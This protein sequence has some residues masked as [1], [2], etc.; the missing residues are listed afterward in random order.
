MRKTERANTRKRPNLLLLLADQL[1]LNA[2][3]AY[4]CPWVRTPNI[5]SLARFGV[6]FEHSVCTAPLCTP[7]RGSLLTGV[8]PHQHKAVYLNQVPDWK[9]VPQLGQALRNT[10]YRTV[11]GG[12]WHLPASYPL[13]GG[14]GISSEVPGF[15]LLP[16]FAVATGRDG[17]HWA[18]GEFTDEP[19]A[20]AAAQYI[21]TADT[22]PR[23]WML[24]LSFHQPHDICYF[25]AHPD[26]YPD[27]LHPEAA[28]P[29]PANYAVDPD[30]PELLQWAR[31]RTHYANEVAAAQAFTDADWRR[32]RYQYYRMV[33]Q[34]DAQVGRVLHALE[35]SAQEEDTVIIFTSDHGD[36]MAAHRWAAKLSL[37]AE[38]V[39]VPLIITRFGNESEGVTDRSHLVSGLDIMP[40]LL[41]YAGAEI[42]SACQGH[43]LRPLVVGDDIPWRSF[44]VTELALDPADSRKRGHLLQSLGFSYMAYGWGDRREQFFD[45]IADLGQ[46][47]NLVDAPAFAKELEQHRLWLAGWLAATGDCLTGVV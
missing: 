34:L 32:Y 41:D 11:W 13:A 35:Q 37:Y 28:P 10:G 14:A 5:D 47:R 21:A 36:G 9:T 46:T 17:L 20:A 45:R 29:L 27:P 30:E 12:K 39:A 3:G 8:M 42:P 1:T 23:P 26:W 19:L 43:S 25:P 16:F 22:D 38:P 33:E 15:D 4:G 40:T 7:S 6:R 31:T 18:L 24:A 44:T 2:V